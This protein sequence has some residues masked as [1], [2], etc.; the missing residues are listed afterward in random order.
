ML[1]LTYRDLLLELGCCIEVDQV[2][3]AARQKRA[4]HPDKAETFSEAKRPCIDEDHGAGSLEEVGGKHDSR[5]RRPS[6]QTGG[7]LKGSPASTTI[8]RQATAEAAAELR[9]SGTDEVAWHAAAPPDHRKFADTVPEPLPAAR[10][11]TPWPCRQLSRAD[12][13]SNERWREALARSLGQHRVSPV[14]DAQSE[15][16]DAL[17]DRQEPCLFLPSSCLPLVLTFY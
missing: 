12:F 17:R 16:C 4:H 9:D 15:F 6:S 5:H 7:C 10:T 2:Y 14:S 3:L 11:M 1:K 13:R 8:P